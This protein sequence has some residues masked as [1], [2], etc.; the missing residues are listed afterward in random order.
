MKKLKLFF[1]DMKKNMPKHTQWVLLGIAFVIVIMLV[2]LLTDEKKESSAKTDRNDLSLTISPN[3]VDLSNVLIGEKKEASVKISASVPTVVSEIKLSAE[4]AG[5][6]LQQTCTTMGQISEKIPCEI[7]V[8]LNPAAVIDDGKNVINIK[9][10]DANGSKD[11][12]KLET[13]NVKFSATDKATTPITPAIPTI[14]PTPLLP[15]IN[16]ISETEAKEVAALPPDLETI[17]PDDD[18]GEFLDF[19]SEIEPVP[20]AV[21]T[22]STEV[23]PVATPLYKTDDYVPKP[24]ECYQFAFAGYNNSGKQIGWVKPTGGAYMFHPFSDTNCSAPTGEYNPQTGFITALDN[25]SKKIGSDAERIGGRGAG[26]NLEMPRLS[27]PPPS[28][29]VHRAVQSDTPRITEA[30]SGNVFGERPKS[31][32]VQVPSSY[33]TQATASS[34]PYDRT[35]VLRHFK[36]IPATIVNEI[37]AVDPAKASRI[38]VQATVDRHVYADNGRTIVVPAGTLMLGNVVGD[39]PGPY[40][41]IGRINIE[42]YRFIRPDGVEFNFVDTTNRP[43]SGD[44]QGRVG[45]PGYGSSDY[46]EQMVLPLLSAIV[47]AATNL[48]APIS[49]RIVNQIDLDNN[50]VVQSGNLRSSELAKQEMI[51]SWNKVTEKL[52]IDMMDNTMPPF[53]IAA[54]TRITVFSPTDLIVTWCNDAGECMPVPPAEEYASAD[55]PNYTLGREDPASMLGQVR[56]YQTPE[57][58]KIEDVRLQN[59]M[60]GFEQYQAKNMAAANAYN[61]YLNSQGGILQSDGT[62][63][64]P[65]TQAYNQQ[66]LGIQYNELDN[67]NSVMLNPNQ[68]YT[69]PT[70]VAPLVVNEA[71]TC[72]GGLLP[73]AS[74]CCPGETFDESVTSTDAPYGSCC[75]DSDPEGECF[76]PIE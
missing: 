12:E 34:R 63:L 51:Q 21:T 16:D 69:P 62:V 67:G 47:P 70:T 46:L 18:F 36:P 71:I 17:I 57:G 64:N 5:L 55:L 13:V 32:S 25:P 22:P 59:I 3:S 60:R 76:P 50:V 38:P 44:S 45:V 23:A 26:A 75:P 73:D 29:Q 40:K 24:E 30:G 10:Y 54:G 19:E 9:Y 6:S 48:I 43:F 52:F 7:T 2:L 35:F 33:G 65:G 11:M 1:A 61:D 42:W 56:Y 39:M 66:V 49:D 28:R 27:N 72:D 74:G 37:R 68:V 31:N 8:T 58:Q 20:I 15:V 53:S 41:T 4:S 14:E